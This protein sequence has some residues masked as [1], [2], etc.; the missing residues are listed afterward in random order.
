MRRLIEEIRNCNLCSHKGPDTVPLPGEGNPSARVLIVGE[1]PPEYASY[2]RTMLSGPSGR[3]LKE[4]INMSSLDAE[5]IYITSLLKCTLPEQG[6]RVRLCL[7]KCL[8]YTLRQIET[9]NPR[10]VCP[11]GGKVTQILTGGRLSVRKHRAIPVELDG[12]IYFP[13]FHPSELFYNYNLRNTME[14]DFIKLGNLYIS[15]IRGRSKYFKR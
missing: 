14:M 7:S 3:I 4:L 15:L 8:P 13:L 5:D 6:D 9:L 2:S 10:I 12:R 1:Q 11:L